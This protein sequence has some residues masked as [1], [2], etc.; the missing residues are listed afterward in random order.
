MSENSCA[1]LQVG[2]VR[3]PVSIP[4]IT[5]VDFRFDV[6]LWIA[7]SPPFGVSILVPHVSEHVHYSPAAFGGV[8]R[9]ATPGMTRA[10]SVMDN[11]VEFRYTADSGSSN[12]DVGDR[13]NLSIRVIISTLDMPCVQLRRCKLIAL[14]LSGVVNG[15]V[16]VLYL[17]KANACTTSISRLCVPMEQHNHAYGLVCTSCSIFTVS[18][19]CMVY[20]SML[21]ISVIVMLHSTGVPISARTSLPIAFLPWM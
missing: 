15:P 7:R 6:S 14:V 20:P 12:A 19:A 10:G 21:N 11:L 17:S 5:L 18:H 8:A 4:S 2:S 1:N 9:C 3:F 13:L 16:M